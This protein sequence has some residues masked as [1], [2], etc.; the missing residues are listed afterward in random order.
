MAVWALKPETF[1]LFEN[2]IV[3]N[4]KN[5]LYFLWNSHSKLV[6][7]VERKRLVNLSNCKI[8]PRPEKTSDSDFS[9]YDADSDGWLE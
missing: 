1:V 5:G 9:V 3:W 4:K 7:G 2:K 6:S 8:L